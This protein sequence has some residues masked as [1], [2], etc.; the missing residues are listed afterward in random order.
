M[1]RPRWRRLAITAVKSAV[2]IVVLW[3][4]GRHVLR[5]YGDLQS[6]SESLHFEP[7]WLVAGGRSLSGRAAG[8][9][10]LLRAYPAMQLGPDRRC[11][12]RGE[13]TS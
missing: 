13:P 8:L 3:A 4:V 1:A 7:L 9:R 11:F 2:A 5:T 10:G 6:R 12:R